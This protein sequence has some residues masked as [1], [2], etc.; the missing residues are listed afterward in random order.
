MNLTDLVTDVVDSEQLQTDS[1]LLLL[2][3]PEAL[4]AVESLAAT[5]N[6]AGDEPDT[7]TAA[8]AKATAG[9]SARTVA[10]PWSFPSWPRPEPCKLTECQ[11]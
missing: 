4:V 6:A 3:M 1:H 2:H 10:A 5:L 7:L 11:R 9:R 8:L